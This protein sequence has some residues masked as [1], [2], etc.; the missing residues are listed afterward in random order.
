MNA[1]LVIGMAGSGGDGIVSAGESLLTAA[2]LLGYHG[3]MTKSFGPQIRGGE[4]SFKL[5]LATSKVFNPG[6]TLDVAVA[7]NWEDFL[8]FGGELPVGGSTTVVYDSNTKVAPDQIPLVGV[9]P[10]EVL[11]V[12]IETM[13]RE[14]AGSD[15]AK[16]TVV[17]GLMSG[18]LGIGKDQVLA[19]IRKRLGKKSKEVLAGAEAAF[20]AG[21]SYAESHPLAKDRAMTAPESGGAKFV[22]D[23]N[24]LCGAA[25]IASGC[26]FFGGYPI[27]PSTEIMQFLTREIWKYGGT[28]LQAEDEIAGIG[29]VV[30]A[31]F[32]GKKAMTATSGP[33]M[34]L[35]T[36]ILGLAS[37]AEL[38]LVCVN[39][40]RG[41]P[42]TG[43]PTKAEQSDLFQAAF[44]AHGDVIRPL[45]APM[46]AEDMFNVTVEAFN[47]AE[48]YQTPVIILSDQEIGQRK[49][50]A[51][52]ID[53]S[54]L[55]VI[56]RRKPAEKELEQYVRFRYTESGISP[57]SHPG[58]KGGNYLASG[59]EHNEKGAPTA[60][61][62]IHAKMNDKRLRKFQPLKAR[63]DLFLHEGSPDAPLGVISWGSVAGVA[64]EAV[65]TAAAQG[66]KVK[67]LVPRLL[68]P[69]SEEVFQD[70]FLSVKRG[71]VV[72]QNHQ[73]QFYRLLRMFVDVPRG[74][75]TLAKS[76]SNLITPSELV[77]RI[78]SMSLAMQQD[79]NRETS[80]D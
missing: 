75:E 28:V 14:T 3:V 22:V 69:I 15:R 66:I 30:G 9:K 70:F 80:A 26:E 79:K 45:L 4:S 6:G 33:G 63:R 5:R 41:G 25:A 10:A 38:P 2:A 32:A 23:G 31:S 24:D 20:H 13:A 56:E 1:D 34:S 78:R 27:T 60:N 61:G 64:M 73:S 62:E 55:Q 44:S 48:Y 72:E 37:I 46:S 65:R 17:L 12:P 43:I 16:N 76:G 42:S 59:I 58:M 51:E 39:V 29:A 18:W 54:K 8:K 36:E 68:Y 21:L 57:I 40:Q 19:G 7:L 11:A 47:I 74:I 52:P 71:L 49:E 35:K 67:L 53:A 50:T 77:D